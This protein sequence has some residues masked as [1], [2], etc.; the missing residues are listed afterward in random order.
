M[1]EGAEDF[2]PILPGGTIGMIGGGQLGRMF[3]LA[4]RRM[5]YR[6]H[7]FEPSPD[8]PSGQI[9]DLQVR[10]DYD[11][12]ASLETFVHAVD[13]VTFEFENIP[14]ASLEAVAALRPVRPRPQV[15][16]LCQNRAR[17][18]EFLTRH[19]F[20]CARY[21]LVSSAAE[22]AVA[23][24]AT[25]FPC[26][27]KTADFGYDGK[28]QAKLESAA[29]AAE[30]WVRLAAP[31]A[32]IEEW[33]DFSCEISVV[34][35]RDISGRVECFPAAE[36]LHRHHILNRSVVPAR[37]DVSVTKEA[38]LLAVRLARALE[39]IG[40]LAVEFFVRR[41]G[42]LLVNELAPRPHNSG[43]FT[44][45]ASVT[46]QFEQQV[47]A[48]CGLP[49]GSSRALSAAVMVNLLG[50][51]W[52]DGEPDWASLLSDPEVKLHLYGKGEARPGRKMG[53]FCV[54]KPSAEEAWKAADEAEA[55]LF[56]RAAGGRPL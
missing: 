5:G 44:Q 53:H 45:D 43:H 41:D 55:R 9:S 40:L 2:R 25:G 31:R 21:T 1:M 50:E 52:E 46:S 56:G 14:S 4:A 29:E 54:L 33:I 11:D 16:H 37:V 42:T 26:V 3:G 49:L 24:A 20:P 28:G 38:E 10:S 30:A 36:N 35:A 23:A 8:S 6:V 47:R 22:A 19:G 15:L 48:V 18:K 7:T 51:A 17:E 13:V 39:V 32:V 34:C 27:L 12:V